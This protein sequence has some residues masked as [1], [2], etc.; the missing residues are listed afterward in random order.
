[1]KL[2]SVLLIVCFFTIISKASSHSHLHSHSNE[3]RFLQGQ[4]VY[5]NLTLSFSSI[6]QTPSSQVLLSFNRSFVVNWNALRYDRVLD[7]QATFG[8]C[9]ENGV[10][11]YATYVNGADTQYFFFGNGQHWDFIL[12]GPFWCLSTNF[13]ADN[14]YL[15]SSTYLELSPL[16]S[17]T[18][19]VFDYYPPYYYGG[20]SYG[21]FLGL[22][23]SD[24]K[25]YQLASTEDWFWGLW[26]P[27]GSVATG[28]VTP[29]SMNLDLSLNQI[30]Y[31][32]NNPL[33]IQYA[34]TD[35]TPLD[36]TSSGII[37]FRIPIFF[38]T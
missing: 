26:D 10:N 7:V 25:R 13:N 6:P 8:S 36:S 37:T 4:I 23:Y 22:T 34:N 11:D 20:N 24:T 14:G 32:H 29:P 33:V 15:D 21:T 2:L 3:E 17:D 5:Y 9:N 19:P 16:S 28:W 35:L 30:V 18:N 31:N 38:L 12:H 27:F 1:M